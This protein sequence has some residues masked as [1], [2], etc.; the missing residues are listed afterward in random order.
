MATKPRLRGF[1]VGG[2]MFAALAPSLSGA[3]E[4]FNPK[5]DGWHSWSV[6]A[7]AGAIE[8]CCHRWSGT[9]RPGCDLGGAHDGLSG[10]GEL[11][12][13]AGLTRIYLLVKSGR[14]ARIAALSPHCEIRN[15]AAI[16]DHGAV[17]PDASADW[18]LR[19]VAAD[20]RVGSEALAALS[21]HGGDR[22]L[23]ALVGVVES[24]TDDGLRQE[25]LFWLIQSGSDAG[26]AYVD[27]LLTGD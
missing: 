13:E 5:T 16:T 26:F 27:R 7:P 17:D 9:G 2:M 6:P 15:P 18:L 14:P 25:A 24:G 21:L 19:F 11:P 23:Q 8:R 4:P 22:A 10:H 20:S 1:I 3:A 12:D